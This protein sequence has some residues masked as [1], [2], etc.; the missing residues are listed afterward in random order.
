MLSNGAIR[1]FVISYLAFH[2][3][4]NMDL[5]WTAQNKE[6]ARA[7]GWGVFDIWVPP[8]R[9]GYEIGVVASLPPGLLKT[10]EAARDFVRQRAAPGPHQDPLC[11]KAWVIVFHSRI[12][13]GS[14]ARPK[15][16]K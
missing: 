8:D 15:G 10:D 16:K 5:N 11:H 9:L 14:P 1:A 7:Q 4:K 3:Q 12:S 6:A 2:L 13:G